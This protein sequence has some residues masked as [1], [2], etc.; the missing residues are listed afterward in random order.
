MEERL[1]LRRGLPVVFLGQQQRE[2]EQSDEAL[3]LKAA[4]AAL[5]VDEAV[6]PASEVVK[7]PTAVQPWR[8]CPRPLPRRAARQSRGFP[9]PCGGSERRLGTPSNPGDNTSR[10]RCAKSSMYAEY[11]ASPSSGSASMKPE[12]SVSAPRAASSRTERPS[13]M[14]MSGASP[15]ARSR[16]SRA[17]PENGSRPPPCRRG[18]RARRCG[19]CRSRG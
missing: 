8:Q 19:R 11:S 15:S 18:S 9:P 12:R 6:D 5:P 16:S 7:D 17:G 10:R 13:A 4:R 3:A 2:F 1:T 14:K